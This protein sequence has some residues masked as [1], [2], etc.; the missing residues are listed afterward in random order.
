VDELL[1]KPI[2]VER[3]G[4]LCVRFRRDSY[5]CSF[6]TDALFD[7]QFGSNAEYLGWLRGRVAACP[8]GVAHL[9]RGP[10]IVG[11][12]ELRISQAHAPAYVNLFYLEPRERGRGLGAVLHGHVVDVLCKRNVA[13]AE[14][15][16]ASGNER[17]LGFYR[18]HG[19]RELARQALGGLP[20]HRLRLELES[21]GCR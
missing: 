9:W 19:W 12:T 14:L 3:D 16:V 21:A 8:E 20:L 11:Q 5:A 10:R 18:K 4:E 17:A 13:Q 7:E 15:H 2:D 1:F 6:G